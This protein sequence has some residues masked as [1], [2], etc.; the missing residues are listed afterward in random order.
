MAT[1]RYVV[2]GTSIGAEDKRHTS[3]A[4]KGVSN[5]PPRIGGVSAMYASDNGRDECDQPSQ[6]NEQKVISHEPEPSHENGLKSYN[7][8][9]RGR[10]R[11][12]VAQNIAGSE[13]RHFS[14]RLRI[15]IWLLE[16]GGTRRVS[17]HECGSNEV[18]ESYI[19]ASGMGGCCSRRDATMTVKAP[20]V[21][22]DSSREGPSML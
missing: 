18:A 19:E 10:E 20:M 15:G 17:H 7:G 22:M 9:G 1:Y 16:G 14:W 21:Y 11:K 8:D 6:L 12:R 13:A 4:A 2:D 5:S 3:N